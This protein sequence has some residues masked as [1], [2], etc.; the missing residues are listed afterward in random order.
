MNIREVLLKGRNLVEHHFGLFMIAAMLAGLFLPGAEHIPKDVVPFLM[1]IIIF[2]AA[3]KIRRD[4]MKSIHIMDMLGIYSIRFLV[5]PYIVFF[6]ASAVLP[7]YKFA[8]LMLMLLP[9]GATLPAVTAILGGNPM[10]ALSLLSLS[11]LL[12]PFV[13]STS[14]TLLS[15]TD[16]DVDGWGMFKTLALIIF[17]PIGVYGIMLKK[18]RPLVEPVRANSSFMAIMLICIVGLTIVASQREIILA[19]LNFLFEAFLVGFGIYMAL[20]IGGWLCFP[21]KA[22]RERVSYALACGNNN[23]AVGISLAFLYLPEKETIT[24]VTWELAWLGALSLCQY[25][26]SKVR[27]R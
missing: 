20:Y 2:F 7:D 8:I 11:S 13:I 17:L 5:L 25:A 9:T 21:H 23:I 15:G 3:S 24:L 10:V 22:E 14:Y 26:L 6:A 18:C 4:D 1:A 12:A 19:N 27:Q 16:I